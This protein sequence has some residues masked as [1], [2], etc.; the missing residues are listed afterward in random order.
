MV[1]DGGNDSRSDRPGAT[2]FWWRLT[3]NA[4]RHLVWFFI[5][6]L[7]FAGVGVVQASKALELYQSSGVLSASSNPLVPDQ[8][9]AGSGPQYWETVASATSR[10]INEQLRTDKFLLDV[11]TAAGLGDA[12]ASG[13]LDLE[14][15]RSSVYSFADGTSLVQIRATWADPD[16][17]FAL[18]QS[19]IDT[20][21]QFLADTVAS[22]SSEAVKF[23]TEQL[24]QY[25]EEVT[26]AEAALVDYVDSLP[27]D[28]DPRLSETL[29]IQRLTDSVQ[30]AESKVASTESDIEQA[31]LVVAQSTSEAGRSLRVIDAPKVPTS[32]E[33]TLIDQVMTVV[34]FLILGVL[35]AIAA[36]LL[37]TVLDRSVSSVSDLV[38][39]N[40][41][42]LVA[43]VPAVRHLAGARGSKPVPRGRSGRRTPGPVGA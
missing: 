22:N 25:N 17:A 28:R 32:P 5:P 4:F 12:V 13:A 37:S 18:A 14:I 39:I 16:T 42:T 3:D 6:I 36:L 19:T 26:V 11:A 23:Y 7:V 15:V 1:S 34:A 43:T 35:A 20:Y 29:Q 9:V 30:A 27:S 38:G 41:V 21:Q 40:G 8:Q 31:K 33:S 2:A 24:V 10:T